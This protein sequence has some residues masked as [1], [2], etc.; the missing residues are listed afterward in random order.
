M[1]QRLVVRLGR[2]KT[3][4]E[5]T[6][7]REIAD[8]EFQDRST[9]GLDLRPSV[10][11]ITAEPA[12]LRPLVV[13]VRAEHS[14]SFMSPP[15]PVGTLEFN[16]DGATTAQLQPSAG[17]TK[18]QYANSIHAELLLQSI[19]EL[20]ALIATLRL[21]RDARAIS[22]SGN[23]VLAYVDARQAANDPEWTAIVGPAGAEQGEWGAAVVSFR[24]KRDN[25]G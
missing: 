14:A 21:E 10:Y 19:D 8:V 23:D 16:V 17:E 13:R 12:D 6:D 22:V 25:A 24:R 1:V 20:L 4:W 3:A 9:G 11:V 5:K 15:R 7:P 2:R 18:F